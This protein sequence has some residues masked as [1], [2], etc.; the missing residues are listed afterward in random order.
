MF[1]KLAKIISP[2]SRKEEGFTLIEL[3]IVVAIIAILAAIAIPQ[4]SAYR[5]RGYNT[6][7]NSDLRNLKI[8][9][10]AF[11]TDWQVYVSTVACAPLAATATTCTG[12]IGTGVIVSGPGTVSIPVVANAIT[13]S[14]PSTAITTSFG[15]S[16]GVATAVTTTAV[17]AANYT[18]YTS[19][20]S[21]DTIYAA[22]SDRT[23]I[24]QSGKTSTGTITT[25]A[26]KV[27][28]NILTVFPASTADA[29]VEADL[30]AATGW[31]NM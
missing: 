3:L 24:K 30:L 26:A 1:T 4:F 11:V 25:L 16:S 27:P 8:A 9:E 31:V 13:A 18:A 19:H 12:V 5:I 28:G 22:D 10:E 2:V 6:A 23:Q 20:T 15:L 7:A 29:A 17:T 14:T 21:G